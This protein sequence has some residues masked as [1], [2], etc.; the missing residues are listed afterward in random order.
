MKTYQMILNEIVAKANGMM[1]S[2]LRENSAITNS[3]LEK[4]LIELKE[5]QRRSDV[6]I[7][8]EEE[9]KS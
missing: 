6:H 8:I 1:T 7:R 9:M 3:E 2:G 4:V 5:I